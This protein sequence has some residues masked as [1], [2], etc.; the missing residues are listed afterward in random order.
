MDTLFRV[1]E[2]VRIKTGLQG[3]EYYRTENGNMLYCAEEMVEYG[4]NV[5]TIVDCRQDRN[6][7][8]YKLDIDEM[9]HWSANML[10]RIG[11]NKYTVKGGF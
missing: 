7:I 8:T 6:M 1:G 9:Y 11:R 4:G 2:R 5:S 10:E 3:D